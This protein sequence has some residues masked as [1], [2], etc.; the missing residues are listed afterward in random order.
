MTTPT[1]ATATGLS[2]TARRA[3]L[4]VA[5]CV[6]G[7]VTVGAFLGSDDQFPFGP[8]RMYATS[9]QSTGE[10]AVVALQMK[11]DGSDWILVRP[12]P[13]T[14]GMNVAEF[15]GQLPRFEE[16]PVLLGAVAASQSA[17][18]PDDPPWTDLRIVRQ[19][20]QVVDKVPTGEVVE[21]VLAEWTST[22]SSVGP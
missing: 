5:A 3:R 22:D 1:G 21:T 14:V 10:V 2:P 19:A 8:F 15:E 18:H 17:L 4:A 7:L 13:E 11:S 6:F 9:G 16:D 12:S 20:T